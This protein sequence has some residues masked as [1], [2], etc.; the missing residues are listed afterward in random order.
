LLIPPIYRQ[1]P[2]VKRRIYQWLLIGLLIRF[3]FMPITVH[4]DLVSTYYRSSFIAYQGVRWFEFL[5]LLTTYLHAFFLW[6]LK[7]LVPHTV[8]IFGAG[9]Y[10]YVVSIVA[11]SYVFRTLFLFKVPYLLFDLGCAFL[12]LGILQDKRKGLAVFIFWMVNPVVIFAV[13]IMGR[14]ESMAMFFILLSLYYARRSLP[15]KSLFC[16]GVSGIVRLYPLIFLPFFVIVLGKKLRQRLK[17][18]FWGLLPLGVV[19]V[20]PRLFHE[21]GEAEKLTKLYHTSYLFVMRLSLGYLY[22]NIYIF[23]LGCTVLFLYAYFNTDHSFTSLWKTTFILL[24]VFFATCF[25]HPQYFMWLMPFL[26][27]EVV[28]NKKFIG[29]FVGQVLC[30]MV[31]TF[32]FGGYTSTLLLT[33]IKATYFKYLPTPYDIISRYYPPATFIGIFRSLFSAIC[34]W[35]VYLVLRELRSAKEVHLGG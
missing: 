11:H 13:Y 3:F 30:L 16:L 35:M 12:F 27:F 34:L 32:H 9:G 8:N 21:V 7:P 20:L 5:P 19:T 10:D 15:A 28:E 33:P 18:A 24:L 26:A 6:I 4:S 23:P 22:D 17:L 25:F 1:D 2:S 14:Y 29:L 31:Y